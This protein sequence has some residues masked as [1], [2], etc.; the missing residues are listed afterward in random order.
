ME[1]VRTLPPPVRR[2]G[3]VVPLLHRVPGGPCF[4]GPTSKTSPSPRTLY[5]DPSSVLLGPNPGPL[6]GRGT[7]TTGL[8]SRT[9]ETGRVTG[10][11]FGQGWGWSTHRRLPCTNT[12][13]LPPSGVSDW[14]SLPQSPLFTPISSWVPFPL[15]YSFPDRPR[16]LSFLGSGRGLRVREEKG[17]NG[18][19]GWA[20][21]DRELL[22]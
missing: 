4:V 20:G 18:A 17:G 9:G 7:G 19:V 22:F 8:P 13:P 2:E 21:R 3:S 5:L 12:L 16:N 11:G 10:D 14:T 1:V 6:T 15:F